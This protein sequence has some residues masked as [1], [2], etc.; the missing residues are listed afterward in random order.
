[1][2]GNG[3]AYDK[4]FSL[5]NSS[6]MRLMTTPQMNPNGFYQPSMLGGSIEYDVDLHDVECGC[7][8]SL[9]LV[10]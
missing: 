7:N 3:F 8:A 10:E 4:K 9:L 1:M 2:W 6:T 5:K